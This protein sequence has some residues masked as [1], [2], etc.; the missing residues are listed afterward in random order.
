MSSS[1][2]KQLE[3]QS[4]FVQHQTALR[5]FVLPLCVDRSA[6]DDILQ[7]TFLT[8]SHKFEDFDVGTSFLAWSRRIAYYHI[9]SRRREAARHPVSVLAQETLEYLIRDAPDVGQSGNEEISI[10][11][12]CVAKLTPRL[13]Q[14]IQMRYHD[15]Q[16]PR[17]IADRLDQSAGGINVSLKRARRALRDC[18]SAGLAERGIQMYVPGES[19]P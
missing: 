16:S 19:Q 2:G 15:E 5:S 8:I 14:L 10:L 6:S 1:K 3:V 4:L 7:E 13:K 12:D 18:L 17:E 11:K 9:L